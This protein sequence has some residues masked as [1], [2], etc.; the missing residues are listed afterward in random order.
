MEEREEE[1]EDEEQFHVD[2]EEREE[3]PAISEVLTAVHSQKPVMSNEMAEKLDI[4]M[5]LCF[6]CLHSLCHSNGMEHNC[7]CCEWVGWEFCSE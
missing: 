4:M 2:I 7:A 6:E 5:S 1:A 3:V